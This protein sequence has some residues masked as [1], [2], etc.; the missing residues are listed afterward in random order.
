VTF[1][2]Y[3]SVRSQR[4]LAPRIGGAVVQRP[5]DAEPCKVPLWLLARDRAESVSRVNAIP[6]RLNAWDDE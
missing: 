5:G 6:L 4:D 3:E 1:L 2:D